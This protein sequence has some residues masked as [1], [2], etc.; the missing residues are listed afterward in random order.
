MSRVDDIKNALH[1]IASYRGGLGDKTEVDTFHKLSKILATLQDDLR[2]ELQGQTADAMDEVIGKLEKDLQLSQSDLDLIRLWMVSDAE[3]YVQLEKDSKDWLGELD[4]LV[5]TVDGMRNHEITPERAA[6]LSGSIR[7]AL[8]V[9]SD[10][11]YFKQQ[12]NRLERFE[13]ATAS[14]SADD[15]R[16]LAKILEQKRRSEDT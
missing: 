9:I 10:I 7:D 2:E 6:K 15:K 13:Q 16:T 1:D 8:R 11:V 12:A 4:R 5:G 14:L 3:F